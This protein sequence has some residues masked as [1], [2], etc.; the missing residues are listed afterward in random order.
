MFSGRWLTC[1]K[2][3]LDMFWAWAAGMIGA[4]IVLLA[5]SQVRI[6]ITFTHQDKNDEILLNLRALF[7]LVQVNYYV[8]TIRFKNWAEGFEL[9]TAQVNVTADRLMKDQKKQINLEKM[10]EAYEKVQVLLQHC[11]HFLEWLSGTMRRI[12]CTQFNWRTS[13][14]IGDAPETALLVGS[15][16]GIKSMILRFLFRFIQLDTQPQLQVMPAFNQKLFV[17]EGA[18][19]LQIRLVYLVSAGLRLLLRILKVKGGLKVWRNVLL[20]AGS[21][22][23]T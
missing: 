10:K 4:L 18:C 23:S 17:I 20:P 9:H 2:G 15:I 11:F 6:R 7:G 13:V 1:R 5:L 8:P 14:G 12:H 3:L 19:I 16:W 22:G 21:S